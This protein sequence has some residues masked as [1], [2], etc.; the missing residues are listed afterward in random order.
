MNKQQRDFCNFFER[1]HKDTILNLSLARLNESSGINKTELNIPPG[2]T[3]L[4]GLF[5]IGENS[6]HFYDHATENSLMSL[7]RARDV[8]PPQP[9]LL[10]IEYEVITK[11]ECAEPK[12][13][14]FSI[15]SPKDMCVTISFLDT[16]Q[17]LIELTLYIP[18]EN[19]KFIHALSQKAKEIK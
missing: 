2:R 9:Q 5:L 11:I 10:S 7:F 13:S 17:Q 15:F 6:F 4:W 19:K 14:L 18:S 16:H 8:A 1:T 3:E 12:K